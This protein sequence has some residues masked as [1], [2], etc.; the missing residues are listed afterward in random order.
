MGADGQPVASEMGGKSYR[1]AAI[2]R[3]GGFEFGMG[4]GLGGEPEH[5]EGCCSHQQRSKKFP[6][7]G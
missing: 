4:M 6:K 1:K 5:I 3:A 7:M 2:K